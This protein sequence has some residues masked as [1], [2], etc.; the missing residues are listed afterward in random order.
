MLGK[1]QGYQYFPKQSVL[2]SI[3]AKQMVPLGDSC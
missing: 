2:L 3:A 1:K